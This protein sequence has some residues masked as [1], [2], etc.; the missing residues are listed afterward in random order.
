[1]T[2]DEIFYLGIAYL[3]EF[4]TT[5]CMIIPIAFLNI[6]KGYTIKMVCIDKILL[7]LTKAAVQKYFDVRVSESGL[8]SWFSCCMSR[9]Y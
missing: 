5:I 9:N 3:M 7:L 4:F 8:F 6:D 2:F 1:M